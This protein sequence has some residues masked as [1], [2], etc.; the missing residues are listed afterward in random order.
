MFAVLLAI[1]TFLVR[2]VAV[3]LA[4]RFLAVLLAIRT[5]L[6]VTTLLRFAGRH[7]LNTIEFFDVYEKN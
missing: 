5:T 7:S 1:T 2:L 3:L 4:V 6:F